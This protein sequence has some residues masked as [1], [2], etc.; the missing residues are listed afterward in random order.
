M[1]EAEK[2]YLNIVKPY[3]EKRN[4]KNWEAKMNAEIKKV[5]RNK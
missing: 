5:N 1:I 2:K 3:L 4:G